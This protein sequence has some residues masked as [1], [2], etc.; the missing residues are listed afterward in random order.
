MYCHKKLMKREEIIYNW[1]HEN[2]SLY[3]I[4]SKEMEILPDK[5]LIL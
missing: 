2:D 4:I 5:L 3:Q 1:K